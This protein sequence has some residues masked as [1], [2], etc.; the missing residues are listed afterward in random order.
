MRW[1]KL[2]DNAAKTSLQHQ[3]IS[4]PDAPAR[5]FLAGAS[6]SVYSLSKRG[7]Y[8]Q[9]IPSIGRGSL[10]VKRIVKKAVLAKSHSSF[11][12]APCNLFAREAKAV[13]AVVH[14]TVVAVHA[15]DSWNGLPYLVMSSIAGQSLQQR[16]DRDGPLP[17][18]EVLRTGMQAA[19]GLAAAHGQGL[20]HRDVKP[21]NILLENRVERVKL[22]DF[23]LAR[24]VDDASLTQSGVVSG[25]PQYMSPEQAR[26]EAVDHRSDLFGLGSVLFHARRGSSALPGQFDARRPAARLRRTVT[27]LARDQ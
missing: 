22:S 27:A 24:A 20:V 5:G 18:K 6:G 1:C 7:W 13:A 3:V 17:I 26:G 12:S 19:L 9:I 14:D 16:V 21:A 11:G 10:A 25:T 2:G 4:E 8:Y 15:V 23:G